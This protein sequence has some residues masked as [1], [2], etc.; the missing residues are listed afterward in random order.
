MKNVNCAW[1]R[2]GMKE[3]S[4]AA[5]DVTRP[6]QIVGARLQMVVQHISHISGRAGILE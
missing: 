2:V 5:S 3:G 4:V 6:G 1:N